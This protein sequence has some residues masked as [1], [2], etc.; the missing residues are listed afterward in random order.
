MLWNTLV[1]LD[2]FNLKSLLWTICNSKLD[3]GTFYFIKF[4]AQIINNFS[5]SWQ[6]NL[7]YARMI[8]VL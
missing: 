6:K 5:K 4:L 7:N 8:K 3:N 1:C 2:Y